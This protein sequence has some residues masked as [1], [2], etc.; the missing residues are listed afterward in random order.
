[1]EQCWS[2]RVSLDQ[3]KQVRLESV[4]CELPYPCESVQVSTLVSKQRALVNFW[5]PPIVL[6]RS[7]PLPVMA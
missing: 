6:A 7:V 1:M 4:E 5:A 2:D 3:A